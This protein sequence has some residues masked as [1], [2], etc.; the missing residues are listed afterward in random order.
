MFY[1]KAFF[2]FNFL[3][4]HILCVIR[5]FVRQILLSYCSRA[6]IFAPPGEALETGAM[7]IICIFIGA[8]YFLFAFTLSF[9][10]F[11]SS[12][13]FQGEAR[14]RSIILLV[15]IDT[16]THTS[17]SNALSYI[18]IC[19]WNCLYHPQSMFFFCF[20]ICPNRS[21]VDMCT[22]VYVIL[23]L[24]LL[25]FCFVLSSAWQ[26]SPTPFEEKQAYIAY[27]LRIDNASWCTSVPLPTVGCGKRQV[28]INILSFCNDTSSAKS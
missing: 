4:E 7:Y 12:F 14:A 28:R 25:L 23:F 16:H 6:A 2:F 18:F 20:F 3:S 15:N 17:S 22:C 19:E 1:T 5:S 8:T 13:F 10:H 11:S 26:K 21:R 9:F 24:L 27:I